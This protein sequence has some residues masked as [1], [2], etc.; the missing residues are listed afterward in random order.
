MTT[1]SNTIVDPQPPPDT[2]HAVTNR[3]QL[4]EL[5]EERIQHQKGE[6]NRLREE[7]RQAKVRDKETRRQDR[8]AAGLMREKEKAKK[9]AE[10]V[11]RFRVYPWCSI[12][13]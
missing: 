10:Q 11:L 12:A 7:A 8:A 6:T 9:A 3:Q 2:A 1:D 5:E 4:Q 13:F